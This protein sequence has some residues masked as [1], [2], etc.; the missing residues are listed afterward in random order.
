MTGGAVLAIS[1]AF[2]YLL[3]GSGVLPTK[4]HCFGSDAAKW[5]IF[6]GA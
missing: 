4:S 2:S 1:A 6:C 3:F 5:F